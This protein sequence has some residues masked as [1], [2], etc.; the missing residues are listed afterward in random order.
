MPTFEAAANTIRSRF[1]S[2]FHAS[3]ASVPIAFDNVEGLY[4]SDGTVIQSPQDANGNPIT[5]V[6]LNIRSGDAHQ[7]SAGKT[8]NRVFRHPGVVIVEIYA[9]V[10]TGDSLTHAIADDIADALR[11]VTVSGVRLYA[12]SPPQSVGPDGAW[13]Q[14][15][16]VTRFEY[17]QTA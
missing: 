7:V 14:S 8:G 10:G 11:G 4:Q 1:Q 12:T 2:Q 15:N 17:D 16:I 6:R 3:R 13:W 5:W 9:V